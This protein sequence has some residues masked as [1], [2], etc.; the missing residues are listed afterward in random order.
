MSLSEK[1]GWAVYRSLDVSYVFVVFGGYI[2][3]KR[4]FFSFEVGF[5]CFLCVE[6]KGE[7]EFRNR[8]KLTQAL[9]LELAFLFFF[10]T[11]YPSDDINK[12]LV[13]EYGES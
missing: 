1:K 8:K 11:G 7:K 10:Q 5:F 9:F 6:R 2:G 3:K 13:S 4:R 12:F